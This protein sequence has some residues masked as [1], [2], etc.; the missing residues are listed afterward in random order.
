M[1]AAGCNGEGKTVQTLARVNGDEITILQFNDELSHVNLDQSS[2]DTISKMVLDK[3]IDRKLLTEEA[4][5]IRLNRSPDVTLEMERAKE[6]ILEKAYLKH[7]AGNQP[8]PGDEEI[9]NYFNKHPGMFAERRQFDIR[10]LVLPANA[11][12]DELKATLSDAHSLATTI[13][14]LNRHQLTYSDTSIR[15]TTT[16]FPESFSARMSK[17]EKGQIFMYQEANHGLINYIISTQ[18]APLTFEDASPMIRRHLQKLHSGQ[19]AEAEIARLRTQAK[20]EYLHTPT[21]KAN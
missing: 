5:K 4:M 8:E 16:D 12:T 11:M 20:I 6:Q 7:L 3:L 10:Q 15:M 19:L 2:K 18:P 14:W 13:G 21:S 17:L 9:R 1:L